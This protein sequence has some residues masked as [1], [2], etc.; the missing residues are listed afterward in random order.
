[1]AEQMGVDVKSGW[2]GRFLLK[3]GLQVCQMIGKMNQR[4]L[5]NV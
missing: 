1:M 2:F 5:Q 4:S 3:R